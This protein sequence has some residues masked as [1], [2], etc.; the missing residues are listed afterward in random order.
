MPLTTVNVQILTSLQVTTLLKG[1]ST[2]LPDQT[3]L[4]YVDLH[5]TFT[6]AGP[7]NISATY[8]H[9]YEVFDAHTGN[10]VMWGGLSA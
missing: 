8:L 7:D 10:L 1:E 2:G 9:G 6:F 3:L 4:Y 5:G